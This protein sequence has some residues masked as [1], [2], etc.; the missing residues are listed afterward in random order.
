[1]LVLQTL[2]S[3][4][5]ATSFRYTKGGAQL[6]APFCY[7][8]G[9]FIARSP[10][11]GCISLNF[12]YPCLYLAIGQRVL[13]YPGSPSS[14]PHDSHHWQHSVSGLHLSRTAGRMPLARVRLSRV[15]GSEQRQSWGLWVNYQQIVYPPSVQGE[16]AWTKCLGRLVDL[17]K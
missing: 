1:M 4:G 2:P 5:I 16:K 6:F 9:R 8:N 10:P 7:T 11:L 14:L 15:C 3:I 12:R 17:G 13:A